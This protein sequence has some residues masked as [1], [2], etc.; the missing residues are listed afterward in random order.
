MEISFR[1]PSCRIKLGVEVEY[2]GRRMYCPKCEEKIT[3]PNAGLGTWTTLGDYRLQKVVGEGSSGSVYLAQDRSMEKE[4]AVKVFKKE[5]SQN[6]VFLEKFQREIK[7]IARLAH[8]NIVAAY[9]AGTDHDYRYLVMEYVSGGTVEDHV[10]R[11]GVFEEK[12]ALKI[13][14]LVAQ[15]LD[16]AWTKEHLLHLDLKPE[17]LMLDHNG[18]VKVTDLGIARCVRDFDTELSD[19]ISGTP[20]YMSPEQATGETDLDFRSDLFS[21][22]GT[23]YF[24]LT[25]KNPFG[26]IGVSETL[27][28]VVNEETENPKNLNPK[29]SDRTVKLINK[30]MNK[31]QGKRHHS[32][33]ELTNHLKTD[34]NSEPEPKRLI[35]RKHPTEPRIRLTSPED[36]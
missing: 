11:H 18:A 25:G 26:D 31:D 19:Q 3:I 7:T 16:Y 33:Q 30:M 24:M 27:D 28:R 22:G 34:L 21:L 32:W 20:A 2:A 13:T 9:K 4:V 14:M 12:E 35:I 36:K 1:C 10:I 5:L 15:S 17:N 6:P 23:L 29:I 8:P